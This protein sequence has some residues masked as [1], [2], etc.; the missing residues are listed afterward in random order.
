MKD[1]LV[2]SAWIEREGRRLDCGPYLSGAVEARVLV[3]ALPVPRVD[4][5]GLT[6]GH[7]GGIYIGQQFARNY[8]SDPEHGVPF[9][10]SSSMLHAEFIHAD[11]LRRSD[12]TSPRLAHLRIEEGTTLVSRSGTIGRMVYV[13]PEMSGMW[14]TEHAIKIVPDPGLVRPGYLYAFLRGAYGRPM[15]TGGTYGAIVQHVEPQHIVRV[16]VPLAPD[17][18]QEEAHRLVTEAA[19]MRTAA[20][21][22]LRAV[23]REIEETVGLPPINGRSSVQSPDTSLVRASALGG[24]MDGLFHSSY[25]RAVLEPLRELPSTR[26]TTVGELAERVFWPPMFKRIRVEDLRYGLPFFGTSALMRS[27][28]DASY[29]LARRTPGFENLIVDETTVLV[30]ASGQLNGIIGHAVLPYGDVVGSPVTHDAMRLFSTSEVAAG[31]L[32]A[33]LGSE[34]GRRQLKVRAFGSSIPH[35]NE[36]AVAGILL[37][38][39]DDAQMEELGRR[40]FAVRTARHEAIGREREARA[41]VEGW[42]EEQAVA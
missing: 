13:R 27:D 10:S 15:L 42:I 2:P 37:P 24:R 14:A 4:L 34:Y 31:Y 19:A 36:S 38:R 22:E 7:E 25:H 1:K 32:F 17:D 23:V 28:P 9:L 18:L 3:E 30:P 40:A 26:R 33:C 6:H 29:L 39:L 12:A 16:P 5:R 35:L 20:S 11:L 8:V 41:L 21:A